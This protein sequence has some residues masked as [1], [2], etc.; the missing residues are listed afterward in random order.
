MAQAKQSQVHHR[1][2]CQEIDGLTVA[3]ECLKAGGAPL[4]YQIEKYNSGVFVRDWWQSYTIVSAPLL[5]CRSQEHA[6]IWVREK[7]AAQLCCK[8]HDDDDDDDDD[9]CIIPMCLCFPSSG[10]DLCIAV[11]LHCT[12]WNPCRIASTVSLMCAIVQMLMVIVDWMGLQMIIKEINQR[13]EN[14]PCCKN[15][16]GIEILFRIRY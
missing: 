4:A 16:F 8:G 12:N 2:V 13:K 1:I 3:L 6:M 7:P 14:I 10:G 9:D 15:R 5:P 11:D